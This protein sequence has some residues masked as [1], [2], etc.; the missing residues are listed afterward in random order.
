MSN[1]F[2]MEAQK[3][4]SKIQHTRSVCGAVH[5]SN[6]KRTKIRPNTTDPK[7][8]KDLKHE[9]DEV[10]RSTCKKKASS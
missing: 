1:P 6:N 9:L 2:I 5:R 3:S 7:A 4:D 10:F 8:C